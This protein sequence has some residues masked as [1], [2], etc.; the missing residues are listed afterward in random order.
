MRITHLR[1]F[2]LAAAL[3]SSLALFGVGQSASADTA[4]DVSISAD[5]ASTAPG[6]TV[7][8]KMTFTNNQTTDVWFVYQSVQPT[9]ATTQRPDLKYALASCSGEG[10]TC[11]GTGTTSIGV[12]YSVPVAPGTSRTVTVPV[13][14]AA[15]SGCNGN[16]A[17]YSYVYYEYND[18]QSHKDG[19]FNSPTTRVNCAT[20]VPAG[21]R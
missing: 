4:A 9:W 12:N 19:V 17:F 16:I 13:Q 8:L 15:D 5:Q 20:P 6:G 3:A 1:R 11:T 18:S 21:T 14:I 7:N 2:G 10:V